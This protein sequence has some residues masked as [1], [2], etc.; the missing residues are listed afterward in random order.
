[1]AASDEISTG[2]RVLAVSLA[3]DTT[4]LSGVRAVYVGTTGD[5]KIDGIDGGTATFKAHPV[6]YLLCQPAKIYSTANG[7]TAAD[8]VLIF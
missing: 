6:G 8:L 1:M 5:V 7:T 2:K 4:G 3:A